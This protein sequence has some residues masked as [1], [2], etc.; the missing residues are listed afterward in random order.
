MTKAHAIAL[1]KRLTDAYPNFTCPAES[2]AL[3][4]EHLLPLDPQVGWAAV[5]ACI[6]S[7]KFFPSLAELLDFAEAES[8][9]AHPT[10]G[11]AWVMASRAVAAG[12]WDPVTDDVVREAVDSVLGPP[13]FAQVSLA[14]RKVFLS[15]YADLVAS[16]RRARI[17][18]EAR[19]SLPASLKVLELQA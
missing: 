16:E 7:N 8:G 13:K 14:D 1:V 19:E 12:S 2:V 18:A 6:R 15:V 3:F 10:P 5:G 17:S 4:V 9:Q 11:E